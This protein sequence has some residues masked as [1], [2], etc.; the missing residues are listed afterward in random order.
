M[1]FFQ[2]HFWGFLNF[3]GSFEV[4]MHN[5]ETNLWSQAGK[6]CSLSISLNMK[7]GS[8]TKMALED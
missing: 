6:D 4:D 3:V 7:F 5:T 8:K 2:I 1:D